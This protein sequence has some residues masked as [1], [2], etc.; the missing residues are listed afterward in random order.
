MIFPLVPYAHPG[1][2]LQIIM[3]PR[4]KSMCPLAKAVRTEELDPGFVKSVERATRL[5]MT[6]RECREF[7]YSLSSQ[8][9]EFLV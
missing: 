7:I 2:K 4:G 1:E 9:D 5:L 6:V 3:D 8:L